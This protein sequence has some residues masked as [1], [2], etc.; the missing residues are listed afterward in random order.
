MAAAPGTYGGSLEQIKRVIQAQLP[1]ERR[2]GFGQDYQATI[3]DPI[4]QHLYNIG[5]GHRDDKATVFIAT[6]LDILAGIEAMLKKPTSATRPELQ[7]YA[8]EIKVKQAMT[9]L[10][11]VTSAIEEFYQQ[12]RAPDSFRANDSFSQ[13][14]GIG[15]FSQPTGM[16]SFK[17][18]EGPAAPIAGAQIRENISRLQEKLIA[19]IKGRGTTPEPDSSRSPP[20]HRG[21]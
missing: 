4:V 21:P 5:Q 7:Q 13:P 20:V 1:E 9:Q 8:E 19:D 14:S 10:A 12:S 6:Q 15:S 2:S 17:V 11:T 3:A 18:D 16:G